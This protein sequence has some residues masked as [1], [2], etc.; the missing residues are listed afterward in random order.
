MATEEDSDKT[1]STDIGLEVAKRHS[2]LDDITKQ[3][4]GSEL[5][6]VCEI[7]NHSYLL[8]TIT[9][10]EELWADGIFQINT[11][12]QASTSF[13]L[14][15][16][17]ASI[18]QINGI[19]VSELFDFPDDMSSER[20]KELTGSEYSRRA[21][22]MG[23]LYLWLGD[24]PLPYVEEISTEYKKLIKRQKDSLSELKNSSARTSGGKSKDLS[25]P[26]KEFSPV[27][28]M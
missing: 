15:R 6:T 28:Q 8:T 11:L 2:V 20:R 16:V 17:A 22:E 27:T 9:A 13:N 26:A 7:G 14:T 24:L 4:G 12:A 5:T 21:W 23:Q 25:S 1:K 10:D 19:P 3:V 18:K